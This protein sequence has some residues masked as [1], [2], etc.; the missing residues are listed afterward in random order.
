MKNK[1]TAAWLSLLLILTT[2]IHAETW[3]VGI[4]AANS[5]SPFVGDQEETNILPMVNYIDDR[6]SYIGGKL[7]YALSSGDAGETYILGQIRS[8]QYYS[9]SLDLNEDLNIEGMKD[10]NS[11]LELGLGM[12]KKT[13]WGQYVLEGL[14]DVTGAHEGF[15]LTAKYSYPKQSGRWLIEPA[16]G[17]QVQ[18]ADLVDYYHGVMVSEAQDGRPAYRGD[19]AINTLSSLMVGYTI[20]AQLLAIA[21]MEQLVLDTSITDSPI[22]SEKQVR[23]IYLGLIYTF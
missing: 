3:Q 18:S 21:G 12:K 7:Q 5:R 4:L 16:I 15:E 23:K 20:N 1:M 9:A 13:A 11:A 8:R 22:V 6:F 2:T 14:T 19:Q 10:R 17:L